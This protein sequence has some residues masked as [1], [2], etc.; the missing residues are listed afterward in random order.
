M[1]DRFYW[2]GFSVFPGIGPK[3]FQKLLLEF[4]TAEAAWLAEAARPGLAKL[5]GEKT[6]ARF[7]N[8]RKVFSPQEYAQ[9]LQKKGVQF[10]T[11]SD[12]EY[13][14]LLK[15]IKNPPI[16]L[17][18]KGNYK[19]DSIDYRTI[20]VVGTRK[21][22][23]YGKEV[24]EMF[25]RDLVDAG[26]IIVSGLAMGV[27]AVAHQT[28]ID[29]KGKTIAV[30]GCG[31][32]CCTPVENEHLYDQILQSGGAIIS[33]YPLGQPPTIGSFPSRNRII[34]G[35]SEAVLVTE[36]AED[37]GAIITASN[38]ASLY[39]PVFAIP[40]SIT[41]SLSKGPY[42][43]IQQG[44][45]MVT[46]SEDILKELKV[47]NLKLKAITQN[48]KLR[49]VT[50]EERK[51]LEILENESLGFDEIVRKSGFDSARIGSLLSIMEMKGMVKS[52][53]G[54]MFSV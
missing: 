8:F 22:T 49:D 10:L 43:L 25:T 7:E 2:L 36:G 31:V 12:K 18:T 38:A 30:L 39:R 44:A 27:D 11:V 9:K 53:E 17:Y 33:E 6:L 29:H 45:K 26:F 14:S 1:D 40:G 21:I 54:G 19:F 48:S 52:L 13:P 5:V 15:Q 28:T 24:T 51:I 46:K 42:K 32:D 41:S 23:Q 34:A 37:S 3:T 50:D 16:V 20:A 4:G 47:Q 35:L